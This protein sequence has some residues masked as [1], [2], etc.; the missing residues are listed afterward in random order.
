MNTTH[1]HT[2]PP[3]GAAPASPAAGDALARVVRSVANAAA[4][5]PRIVLALWLP[6][7]NDDHR[8]VLA[9][10]AFLRAGAQS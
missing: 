10:L 6:A 1:S 7:T 2:T 5:R 9:V 3:P 4:R 8:R